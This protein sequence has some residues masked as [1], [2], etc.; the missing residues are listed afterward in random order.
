MD[1]PSEIKPEIPIEP[2]REIAT[3]LGAPRAG[4]EPLMTSVIGK[5][6]CS[7]KGLLMRDAIRGNQRQSE[8][9]RGNQSTCSMRDF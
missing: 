3:R 5:S 6:T 8:A 4:T 2:W 9:I 1:A 7:M